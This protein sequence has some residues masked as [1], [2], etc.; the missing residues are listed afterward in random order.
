MDDKDKI[1]TNIKSGAKW[2]IKPTIGKKGFEQTTEDVKN[3][4][5]SLYDLF[6]QFFK[7]TNN[8]KLDELKNIHDY[9]E[10]FTN[11]MKIQNVTEKELPEIEKVAK[12]KFNIDFFLLILMLGY[13]I[14]S[15]FGFVGGNIFVSFSSILF[16]MSL[17]ALLV[18]RFIRSSFYLYQIRLKALVPL[19][20]W[21]KDYSAWLGGTPSG[22]FTSFLVFGLLCISGFHSAFADMSTASSSTSLSTVMSWLQGNDGVINKT[23]DL[24]IKML[25][26]LFPSGMPS[27]YQTS[28]S[29]NDIFV[30]LFQVFNSIVLAIA[31]GMMA[32]QTVIGTVQT[33]HE[34]QVLGQKWSTAFAPVRICLGVGSLAPIKGYCLAQLFAIQ[35]LIAGYAV[36][37]GL[38]GIYVEQTV[39]GNITVNTLQSAS[40]S[41][42]I[43][44]DLLLSEICYQ[45]KK[46]DMNTT[47]LSNRAYTTNNSEPFISPQNINADTARITIDYGEQCGSLYFDMPKIG[48]DNSFSNYTD[49]NYSA[50]T[51]TIE[52]PI[53]SA[54]NMSD[55]FFSQITDEELKRQKQLFASKLKELFTVIH[56][57]A[58]SNNTSL[59]QSIVASVSAGSTHDETK[60]V[61]D[62]VSLYEGLLSKETEFSESISQM[63]T[64]SLKDSSKEA[65]QKFV[66][67]SK[68]LGW[69]SAGAL[70][71]VIM[72]IGYDQLQAMQEIEPHYVQPKY[73]IKPAAAVALGQISSSAIHSY[74][75]KE[76][77]ATEI[78]TNIS[79][80]F[81]GVSDLGSFGTHFNFDTLNPMQTIQN[82]GSKMLILGQTA[83]MTYLAIA[84]SVAFAVG[85]SDSWDA[86]LLDTVALGTISGAGKVGATFLPLLQSLATTLIGWLILIGVIEEYVI[87]MVPYILWLYAVLG[88]AAFAVEF[89]IAA[90][91]A[92]FMHVRLDGDELIG[93]QQKPF[94]SLLFNGTMRPTLL[95]FGLIASNKVFSVIASFMNETFS[96]AFTSSNAGS[97]VGI[98]GILTSWT[99]IVYLH[100]NLAVKCLELINRVPHMVTQ[101][102]G[103]QDHFED[104]SRTTGEV[105]GA[106]VSMNHQASNTLSGGLGNMRIAQKTDK[107]GR[108]KGKTAGDQSASSNIDPSNS[109]GQLH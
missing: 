56:P 52:H 34:G 53:S 98:C 67:T 46:R 79:K 3:S 86:K 69:A 85:E 18:A 5:Q 87:P 92:A 27:S 62:A 37:N 107:D 31:S 59:A 35:I 21:L 8:P 16:G 63:V 74:D 28:Q 17:I 75:Q 101:M 103:I 33:A 70:N 20:F 58:A 57:L 10:R 105:K 91:L 43:V 26:S 32:Y 25:T 6:S 94:Y 108:P 9:K 64:D 23:S 13:L 12:F 47:G 41:G 106:I 93:Q 15:N 71:P 14:A 39:T 83:F 2:L 24:S 19:K 100:Y 50:M 7:T 88:C 78:S 82:N 48:L 76:E 11:S 61:A 77:D 36:A 40:P 49:Q 96:M 45:Q 38:W 73:E 1:F 84:A 4:Y 55:A 44:R 102:V 65:L 60:T 72:K 95:L 97:F 68:K 104:P 51:N 80:I 109:D 42:V 81:S 54:Q 29:N 90:P 22:N 99:L 66:Q 30:P 89:V